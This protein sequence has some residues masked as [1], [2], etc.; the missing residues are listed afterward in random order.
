MLVENL[1]IQPELKQTLKE[2]GI[3]ELYPP[4]AECVNK[5]L[6]DG[7][8][9]VVAIPTAS[10]K[11]LIAIL[12]IFEKMLKVQAGKAIYLAPLRALASEKYEEFKEYADGLGYKVAIT[13]GDFDEK[14]SWLKNQDIIIATNEKFDSLIRHQVEWLNE[15]QIIVSDEIHLINDGSRGPVLEVVLSQILHKLP[16][17]QI[18]ALSATI[19]NSYEIAEWLNASLVLSDW[20]P[21]NLKE[22]VFANNKIYYPDRSSKPVMKINSKRK[23]Q[24]SDLYINLAIEGV[25][26][27][28]QSLVFCNTRNSVVSSSKNIGNIYSSY[29]TEG[30]K[31]ELENLA[32]R[33]LKIGEKTTINRDLANIVKTGVAYHHAGLNNKQRKLIEEAFKS[34]LIKILTASPT[35]AAGVN[36]PSRRVIIRSL[37]RFYTNIGSDYIPV[38]EYKQM[39]GRAGRPRYD[40]FGES[41]I[42][43]KNLEDKDGLM[44]RYILA[45]TEEIHSKFGSEPSLRMHLLSFVMNNDIYDLESA[46]EVVSTTFYGYQN[47]GQM[48]FVEENIIRTLELLIE[49][50]MITQN[51]PYK[52][53][54]F[55]KRVSQLYLDPLT[56]L[57]LK[58]SLENSKD[59]SE[60]PVLAYLQLICTTPDVRNFYVKD[61]DFEYLIEKAEDITDSLL[62]SDIDVQSVDWDFFM[63][64]LKT[65]LI[66]EAWI[67][68]ESEENINNYFKINS[69]DI[70]NV[71][72]VAEWL[73]NATYQICKLFKWSSHI[74][75]LEKLSK[76]LK[77][78]IKE[79]LLEL[80]SL[81]NIGRKRARILVNSNINTIRDVKN[82]DPTRLSQLI[83]Q[84]V[85]EA[86]FEHLNKPKSLI[87][88][89]SFDNLIEEDLEEIESNDKIRVSEIDSLA[90]ESTDN[91]I[92][93][94]STSKNH[95]QKNNM[96]K[97]VKKQQK[98]VD[99]QNSLDE[100]F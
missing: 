86:L 44:E 47:D 77:Y 32:N 29:L 21:V 17:C 58:K 79:D 87:S 75:H 53:T 67:N 4:Q 100:F 68:E 99:D 92:E 69:G 54:T 51:E 14:Q 42:V 72:G 23:L 76:R 97:P 66:L 73:I 59:R 15:I 40:E 11:T 71:V 39:A 82:C 45:D 2:N 57:I 98:K 61:S 7:Q 38:L 10:G 5:G 81:P 37:F 49:A 88:Q 64:Q 63:Q 13:T 90:T 8:N 84:R 91:L 35:L 16:N 24:I 30:E 26:E 18:V 6:L 93:V 20:R 83:G 1:D 89:I 33:L 60:I 28:G 62:I 70:H 55:G 25:L 9:M 22:G 31:Q 19:R 74:T 78:G 56:G 96:K 34:R 94:K 43:A 48:Y 46:M 65:A 41:I 80:V 85:A 27:G 50:K 12:A 3:T 36:L 52:A 95:K